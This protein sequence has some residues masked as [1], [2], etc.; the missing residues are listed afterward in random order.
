MARWQLMQEYAQ[1]SISTTLPRS[2]CRSIGLSPGVFSHAMMPLRSGA[3]PQF[4][5]CADALAQF[6]NPA[7]WS[8]TMPPS[9][10]WTCRSAASLFCKRPGVVR[11]GPLQRRRQIEHQRHRQQDGHHPCCDADRTLTASKSTDPLGNSLAGQREEQQRHRRADGERQGQHDDGQA[12][13]RGCSG[14]HDRGQYRARARN[15]EHTQRQTEAKTVGTR[16]NLLLRDAGERPLQQLLRSA[17]RSGRDRSRPTRPAPP[18][19][20]RPAAGATTTAAPSRP[21]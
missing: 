18:S 1:K 17:G 13:V 10:C 4:C 2:A 21:A 11:N 15:I 19:G 3:G 14:H 5:S 7:F 9:C 16:C 20:S 12:D 6:D 8:L